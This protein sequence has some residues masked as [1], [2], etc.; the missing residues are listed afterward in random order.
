MLKRGQSPKGR[1]ARRRSEIAAASSASR[2]RSDSED[3]AGEPAEDATHLRH[4]LQA[5]TKTVRR[6]LSRR[7]LSPSRRCCAC[8]G[9]QVA[10]PSSAPASPAADPVHGSQTSWPGSEDSATTAHIE[11]EAVSKHVGG[12]VNQRPPNH[13]QAYDKLE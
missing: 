8:T 3:T 12:V 9:E 6:R 7:R 4:R 1:I 2:W 5:V 11:N 13:R 10:D